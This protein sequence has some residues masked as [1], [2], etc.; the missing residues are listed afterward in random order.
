MG[1]TFYHATNYKNG[2]KVDR[3]KECD[4][5]LTDEKNKVLES[6]L[7]GSVY[8]AAVQTNESV[9][10]A[11]ILT[12]GADRNDPFFNF[13]YKA[14]DE[15]CGPCETGCPKKILD[16]LTP[17][18]SEWAQEWREKCRNKAKKEKSWLD[19]LDEG[20][21]IVWTRWDGKEYILI[22]HPA[23]YQFKTWFWYISGGYGYI[24]K[25]LVNTENAKPYIEN[26]A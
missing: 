5:L 10:A 3:K 21:K 12:S 14:M 16:L 4:L 8:Y 23:A 24:K 13:G 26:I 9:W 25:K 17:T 19:N 11:V 1:W 15:T 22:K 18:T 20:Q 7:V 6:S 2:G